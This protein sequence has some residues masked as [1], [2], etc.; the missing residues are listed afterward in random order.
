MTKRVLSF[1]LALVC[2][3]AVGAA[4]AADVSFKATL[5]FKPA[6]NAPADYFTGQAASPYLWLNIETNSQELADSTVVI[7]VPSTYLNADTGLTVAPVNDP[8]A[9][10]ASTVTVDTADGNHRA[11]IT[12]TQLPKTINLGFPLTVKTVT[13]TTPD[14]YQLPLS[15]T[16]TPNGGT[17]VTSEGFFIPYKTSKPN[18]YQTGI[19]LDKL[20]LSDNLTVYGGRAAQ[21]NTAY[22]GEGSPAAPVLFGIE[23]KNP[24]PITVNGVRNYA[25]VSHVVTMPTY[26]DVNGATRTAAFDPAINPGWELIDGKPTFVYNEK[27]SYLSISTHTSSPY[28]GTHLFN[29]LPLLRL[30][31][32]GAPTGT[33]L[34]QTWQTTF[35]PENPG[36]GEQPV[37]IKDSHIFRL[38][39]KVP[40]ANLLKDEPAPMIDQMTAKQ[41]LALWPIT[42]KSTSMDISGFVLEDFGLS[43]EMQFDS[44]RLYYMGPT[45]LAGTAEGGR[46]TVTVEQKLG[47]VWAPVA[48]AQGILTSLRVIALDPLAE[49]VRVKADT[50]TV[51][52]GNQTFQVDVRT[53]L[54]D[55]AN[56]IYNADTMF[57]FVNSAKVTGAYSNGEPLPTGADYTS[58]QLQ[59]FL[60]YTPTLWAS[61]TAGTGSLTDGQSASFTLGLHTSKESQRIFAGEVLKQ[62]VIIMD[63]LPAGMEYDDASPPTVTIDGTSNLGKIDAT[64]EVIDNYQGTGRTALIWTSTDDILV[65]RTVN[66]NWRLINITYKANLCQASYRWGTWRKW[67]RRARRTSR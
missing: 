39:N 15:A 14:G 48:G 16:F 24:G 32:P 26:T 5:T 6:D 4:L 47:G 38:D 42:A 36:V 22:I 20:T 37:V 55:P 67:T 35:T 17:A 33:D 49:G 62:P 7:T 10:V 59:R 18:P 12:F 58:N 50:G 1:I 3:L 44:L 21:G 31:F 53:K 45:V 41:E 27:V 9:G 63:L 40:A 51:L 52:R 34:T 8:A 60:P 43:P 23:F 65:E 30:T 54:R 11:T 64:P 19:M 66:D 13:Y 61:K 56:T 2:L 28:Y 46:G 57:K 25:Q 29:G